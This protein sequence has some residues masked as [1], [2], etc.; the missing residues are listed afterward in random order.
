MSR[1]LA[2]SCDRLDCYGLLSQWAWLVPADHTPLMVGA[3]GDWIV[4]APDGSHW[5]LCLLEGDYRQIARDCAEFNRLKQQPENMESWFKADWVEI[6]ARCGLVP[7]IDECLG[8]KIPPILGGE[9]SV[10]NIAVF[11]LRVYQSTQGQ[12][13]RQRRERERTE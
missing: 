9:F 7:K 1:D 13:H 12:L 6:A 2:I 5:V 3:F 11:P 4:G 8:W 10:D